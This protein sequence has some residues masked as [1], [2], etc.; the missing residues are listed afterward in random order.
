MRRIYYRDFV[1][2]KRRW[3]AGE[4]VRWERGRFLTEWVLIV[5]RPA[6]VLIIPEY[7]V[8]R[9]SREWLPPIPGQEA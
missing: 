9:E 8:E 7:L 4:F 6:T 5:Q 3:T 2:G 1:T